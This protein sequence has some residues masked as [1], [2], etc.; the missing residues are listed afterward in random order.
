MSDT[1]HL[2][3]RLR[4]HVSALLA[5]RKNGDQKA[6]QV[7]DLYGMHVRCPGDPGAPALCE[8]VFDDWILSR[9]EKEPSHV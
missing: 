7:I 5:A 6:K 9:C 2:T 4:P 1:N 8:A 3:E